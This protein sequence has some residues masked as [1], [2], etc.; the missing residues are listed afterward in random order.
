[1]GEYIEINGISTWFQDRGS[2]E[3]VVL[4]HG[5]LVDGRDFDGN[6]A[7]LDTGHR[8]LVPDRRAHGRS[9]DDG[10]PLALDT[11][12]ADSAMFIET[13][14]GSR[15]ALVGYSAGTMVAL[16][17]AIRRP[18]LVDRLVLISGAFDPAGMLLRPSLDGPP[19]ADLVQAHG[20]VSPYGADHFDSVLRRIV[21]S[22]DRDAPLSEAEVS[23]I[24]CPT[25]VMCAD[26]DLVGLEHV[27]ATYRAIPDSR[28]AVIPGTSHV[29]L[30]EKPDVCRAVVA[31]FLA[32][33]DVTTFM[34]IRRAG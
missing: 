12:A 24:C 14:V 2:G 21:D 4:L 8:V 30:H 26:D 19:P 9:H 1:M 11:L 25:L 34:P 29:L 18:E 16:R 31:D 5:G 33:P 22:V 32:A 28:L 10:G 23:T 17:V 27:L 20:E 6:L 3:P 13:V 7:G 15:V